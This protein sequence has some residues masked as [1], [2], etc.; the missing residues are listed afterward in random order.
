M[1]QHEPCVDLTSGCQDYIDR[2]DLFRHQAFTTQWCP[3]TCRVCSPVLPFILGI[4]TTDLNL[5]GLVDNPPLQ[6]DL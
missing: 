3:A 6:L 4:V 1:V 5:S 2:C